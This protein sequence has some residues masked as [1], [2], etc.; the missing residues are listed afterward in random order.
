MSVKSVL[1]QVNSNQ[2]KKNMCCLDV[3]L[4]INIMQCNGH[5][6]VYWCIFFKT[7]KHSS[8]FEGRSNGRIFC[9][10]VCPSIKIKTAWLSDVNI[11]QLSFSWISLGFRVFNNARC[12]TWCGKAMMTFTGFSAPQT[13]S[14]SY[15]LRMKRYE[16]KEH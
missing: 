8:I 7:V 4:I 11:T 10:T 1:W 14:T 5:I 6:D 16:S 15:F 9:V 13:T 12:F 2:N 3:L